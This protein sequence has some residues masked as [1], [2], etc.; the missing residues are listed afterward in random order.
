MSDNPLPFGE[1]AKHVRLFNGEDILW[2]LRQTLFH[3][4]D[5][6]P[7][8]SITDIGIKYITMIKEEGD[9]YYNLKFEVIGKVK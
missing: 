8:Y 4:P 7:D 5:D 9:D 6:H 3:L 1:K 2:L